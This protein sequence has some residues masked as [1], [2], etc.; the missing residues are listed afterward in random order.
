MNTRI[1]LFVALGF[2]GLMIFAAILFPDF[3]ENIMLTPAYY[4]HILFLH[5]LTVMLFFVNAVVG[6][7]WEARSLSSKNKEVI[8]HTY[9]TVTWLD[10]HFS[11]PMIILA[12]SSG[13]LLGYGNGG[14]WSSGWLSLSFL[15]FIFSGLVWIVSDIPSQYKIRDGLERLSSSI[16]DIPPDF[17]NLLKRRLFISLSGV[18]PLFI[19]FVLMIYKPD[20]PSVMDWF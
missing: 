9:K 13:I 7:F 5:V 16:A 6:I 15:L 17:M 10:A 4:N 1:V 18:L 8:V 14:I 19:V 20:F 12:V 2:M 3:L 11:S